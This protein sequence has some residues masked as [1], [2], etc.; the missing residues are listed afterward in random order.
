MHNQLVVIQRNPL[1]G[2]GRG[3][4]E[5]L[6]LIRTLR[7]H[8]FQ[9]RMFASRGLLD[10][11]VRRPESAARLHCLVAAG[12]DGTLVSVIDRHPTATVALLPLGT[13]N[14]VARYLKIPCCGKTAGDIIAAGFTRVF[15][16]GLVHQQRFLLMT[17]CGPDARVIQLVNQNRTRNITR[18]DYLIPVLRTL[19]LEPLHRYQVQTDSHKELPDGCH[20]LVTNI[21]RYGFDL[22]FSPDASPEDGSLHVRIAHCRTRL[23]MLRHVLR[24][25]FRRPHPTDEVTCLRADS[26]TITLRSDSGAL[27]L[28]QFD[29]EPGPVPPLSIRVAP[30]SVRLLCHPPGDGQGNN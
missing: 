2:S 24:V 8:G 14:L 6:R 27:P 4:R 23:Q 18:T 20:V 17:S 13:E 30:A 1:S 28:S 3:R 26:V 25:F 10:R 15:D 5:L 29:G 21:P 19:L 7:M 11:Y 22:R 16:S 9:V 12:G